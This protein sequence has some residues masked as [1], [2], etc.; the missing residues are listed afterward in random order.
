M[1]DVLEYCNLVLTFLF[2]LEMFAKHWQLG[3]RA[4]WRDSFNFF[5]GVL[6][7]MSVAEIIATFAAQTTANSGFTVLRACRLLR[8]L[9]VRSGAHQTPM[10]A[11]A[12]EML[13]TCV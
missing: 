5:D 8:V 11:R 6:V 13:L 7:L 12:D 3:W 10:H 4:Y 1:S 9:K 2:A